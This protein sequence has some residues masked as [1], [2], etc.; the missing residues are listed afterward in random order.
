MKTLNCVLTTALFGGVTSVAFAGSTADISVTGTIT[1]GSCSIDFGNDGKFDFCTI[2][3]NG[4]QPNSA[5]R[6]S[7][8]ETPFSVACDA[9]VRFALGITDNRADSGGSSSVLGLGFTPNDERIGGYS[10]A[11]SGLDVD[12]DA[13]TQI[14]SSDGGATWDSMTNTIFSTSRLVGYAS[15]PDATGGPTAI[16]NLS[17]T[18]TVSATYIQPASQLTLTNDVPLDGSAT[19]EL[20]YL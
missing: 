10:L 9:P 5:T 3:A 14:F 1:P 16:M 15:L 11:V 18:L 6:L 13:G 19:I 20:L 12:G 17:G 2:P 4:L 7:P 8:K